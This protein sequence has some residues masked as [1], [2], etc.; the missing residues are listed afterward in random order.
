MAVLAFPIGV[1]L[2]DHDLLLVDAFL[3]EFNDPATNF[4]LGA[5]RPPSDLHV[6]AALAQLLHAIRGRSIDVFFNKIEI[7]KCCKCTMCLSYPMFRI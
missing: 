1:Y 7:I 2:S 4:H 6:C 5:L 3:N